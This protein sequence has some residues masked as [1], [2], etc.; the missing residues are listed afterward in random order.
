MYKKYWFDFYDLQKIYS[1]RDTI[2]LNCGPHLLELGWPALLG[3]RAAGK[4]AVGLAVS[5]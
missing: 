4:S 2:P 1:S 3:A 5:V